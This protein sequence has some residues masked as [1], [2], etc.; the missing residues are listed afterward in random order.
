MVSSTNP[1]E[2][3]GKI[4]ASMKDAVKRISKQKY[5]VSSQNGNGRYYDVQLTDENEWQCNCADF[6]YRHE[7]DR[8]RVTACKH[9]F[10]IQFNKKLREQVEKE[11]VVIEPVNIKDCIFCQS[12]Y[13]K[14]FGIRHNKSGAIQRFICSDC[15]KTFSINLGFEKMKHN[16]KA[17]TT[18]I[19]LYFSGESLR[20]TQ[21]S[22]RLLGVHVSHQTIWNWISKYVSLMQKYIEKLRPVVS[23]TWRA[24]ELWIKIRG[25]MK[26][27]FA[28]MD[29]ET[30]YLIAQEVADSKYKHDARTLFRKGKEAVGKKPALLITDGL[31]VYHDAFNK[32]FYTNT[33]PRSEHVNA[34]K[35]SGD[36]NNN[37]MERFNGEVRDRE[38]VMRS[39]KIKKTPILT[40]YQIY[41]NYI[42]E[43]QGIGNLTPAEK[44]GIKIDG[45]NKWVTLI[46]NAKRNEAK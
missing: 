27:M 13:L 5:M 17:V 2:L 23:D 1:R 10:A 14:K 12:S 3:K 22:I 43:H 33:A 15:N 38:K 46:Q 31:P 6:V 24:D 20:N 40:G 29:D 44:C 35:I 11:L 34:I 26:Y 32:E 37:R 28:L 21:R 39:L 7:R 8:D 25:D 4:I 9:I 18:A 36:M 45:D 19:Q 42:R 30:R 41:H 16:P